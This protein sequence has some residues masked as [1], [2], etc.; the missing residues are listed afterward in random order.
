VENP[1]I[2]RLADEVEILVY[3]GPAG[4][5]VDSWKSL[6]VDA[7]ALIEKRLEEPSDTL[8][9]RRFETVEELEG[10]VLR[11]LRRS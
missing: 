4:L 8:R 7:G 11:E 9:A 10:A 6:R 1:R 2:L 3:D 5:R